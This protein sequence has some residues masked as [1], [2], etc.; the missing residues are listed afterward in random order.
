MEK[1]DKI[2]FTL[3][4]SVLCGL[5]FAVLWGIKLAGGLLFGWFESADV[6]VGLK[7]ALIAGVVLSTILVVIFAVFAGDG[8]VGE[9]TT[10]IVGFFIFTTFFTFSIAWIF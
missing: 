1:E 3:I 7:D 8:V 10:M 4:L 2:A 9:L 6:G 5:I